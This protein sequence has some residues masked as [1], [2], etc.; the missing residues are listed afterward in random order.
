LQPDS[1][2]F[3]N[4]EL[5]RLPREDRVEV[6]K[7]PEAPLAGMDRKPSSH[8]VASYARHPLHDQYVA[9][10]TTTPPTGLGADTT[11]S[12]H[13]ANPLRQLAVLTQRYA[14]TKI[15]DRAATLG[16]LAQA[17]IIGALLSMVF[18]KK[19]PYDIPIFL[20]VVVAIWFG[21]INS[22]TELV[23]EKAIFRRERMVFL[24]DGPYVLSK[25]AVLGLLSAFQS[26]ILLGVLKWCLHLQGP[27]IP[28]FAIMFL[29]SL[30]GLALG[31]L[32]S[33]IRPTLGS[34]MSILPIV[35][36]VQI[37][38]GGAMQPLPSMD[39]LP[40]SLRLP[41][42]AAQLTLSRWGYEAILSI[43]EKARHRIW[44]R[45]ECAPVGC[46][47]DLPSVA[48]PEALPDIPPVHANMAPTREDT[49]ADCMQYPQSPVCCKFLDFQIVGTPEARDVHWKPCTEESRF[50]DW[51]E[52]PLSSVWGN[53]CALLAIVL[54]SFA[55]VF[56]ALKLKN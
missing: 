11:R 5:E 51:R 38:L 49:T 35:L 53:A 43:E 41:Q 37:V 48:I 32:L 1:I 36:T 8:W 54:L 3:F 29:C 20:L 15:R 14:L 21:C 16:L 7:D 34:A 40:K 18:D 17:P 4:P 10:R 44:E 19:D 46:S 26:G 23:K 52:V 2:T 50:E 27:F 6:L 47:F 56:A 9:S 13:K 55:A 22:V 24:Q 28:M 42:W 30:G 25:V 45:S 39:V 12:R 33:A 31:L